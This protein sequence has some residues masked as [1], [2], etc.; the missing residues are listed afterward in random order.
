M[1]LKKIVNTILPPNKQVELLKS[2]VNGLY[3][4]HKKVYFATNINYPKDTQCIFALWHAHQCGLYSL[5]NR[6]KI[7]IMISRSSDGNIIAHAVE[8]LGFR[9]V[10]GSQ[11]RGGKNRGGSAAT[12]ELINRI[13]NEGESG[14]I[15]IDG[16]N[17]PK[18]I[19]KKGILEIAKITGVPIVP[20]TFYGGPHGFIKF[21]TW[22][23][24]SY[25]VPC[26]QLLNIYGDPIFVPKDADEETIEQ[27]RQ[28][29]ENKL[30][31][32]YEYAKNNYK[33]L[34]KNK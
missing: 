7:N 14:A 27:I 2:I 19:V 24:F 32:L 13:E 3:Q 30:K 23:E 22:D 33:K 8:E 6:E 17:G 10:R 12:R 21:K 1:K 4:L 26:K 15:T 29:I 16:P 25:P 11:N 31:E 34:I 20:M 5:H 9:T 28:Q 18:H